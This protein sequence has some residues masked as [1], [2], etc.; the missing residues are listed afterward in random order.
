MLILLNMIVIFIK[1]R[2][3][4]LTTELRIKFVTFIDKSFFLAFLNLVAIFGIKMT[5][6]MNSLKK[7]LT[8]VTLRISP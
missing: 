8:F 6:L 7:K 2:L 3:S 1:S 5:I 4:S